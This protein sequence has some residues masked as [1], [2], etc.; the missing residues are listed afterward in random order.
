MKIPQYLVEMNPVFTTITID[1]NSSHFFHYQWAQFYNQ[2]QES[3]VRISKVECLSGDLVMFKGV[4]VIK[5][6]FDIE[7]DVIK[8]V[9]AYF[10]S[11]DVRNFKI[12]P[13][14]EE[15]SLSKSQS[16]LR[17]SL[18]F[19]FRFGDLQSKPKWNRF[20]FLSNL[21]PSWAFFL[22]TVLINKAP[23]SHQHKQT[24][25]LL[26]PT[27]EQTFFKEQTDEHVLSLISGEVRDVIH[28]YVNR[29]IL[30]TKTSR[31]IPQD[32]KIA[33]SYRDDGSCTAT[34]P[35]GSRCCS[36]R[37]LHFDHRFILFSLGGPHRV[38]NLTLLCGKHNRAKWAKVFIWGYRVE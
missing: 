30:K 26:I 16:D 35:D 4:L 27:I 18:Q 29:R 28:N 8:H 15:A 36:T 33:V 37:D 38:W 32:V 23:N 13:Y 20:S 1:A 21:L 3:P 7:K 6:I 19:R 14:T 31:Y 10:D 5:E 17:G 34:L 2:S 9:D 12:N 22:L 11:Y 24:L 25:Q